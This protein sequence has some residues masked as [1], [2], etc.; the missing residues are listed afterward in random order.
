MHSRGGGRPAAWKVP[1]SMNGGAPKTRAKPISHTNSSTGS[2]LPTRSSNTTIDPENSWVLAAAQKD[3]PMF[4]PGWEDST[5][6]NTFAS[7]VISGE[8]MNVHT[9]RSGIEYMVELTRWYQA[10]CQKHSIG[11]F[12]IGGGIAGD[13]PICVVPMLEQSLKSSRYSAL[14]L[15]L[16]DQRLDHELWVVLG[17]CSKR[18]DH[19]GQALGGDTE[20]YYRVRRQHRGTAH[21]RLCPGPIARRVHVRAIATLESRHRPFHRLRGLR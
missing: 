18:K 12:Q 21:F 5:L 11:F 2:C 15:F 16:P 19:M 13:F 7:Y 1:C 14:G 9:V 20:V 10:T 4:V 17:C 8:I 3:L 6:G